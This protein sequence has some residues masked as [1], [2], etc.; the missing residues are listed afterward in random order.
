[1][2]RGVGKWG[3][4]EWGGA[5]R[6]GVAGDGGVEEEDPLMDVSMRSVGGVRVMGRG[7]VLIDPSTPSALVGTSI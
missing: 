1:M 7:E 2:G 5:V 4:G 6:V 3:F